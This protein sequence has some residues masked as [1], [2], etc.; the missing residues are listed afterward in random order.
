MACP[1]LFGELG[2]DKGGFLYGGGVRA[3]EDCSCELLCCHAPFC[4]YLD[5]VYS[6]LCKYCGGG[7][8]DWWQL[9]KLVWASCLYTCL[10]IYTGLDLTAGI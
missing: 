2:S 5:A 8:R 10:K 7:V 9:I 6:H 4:C 1:R 3:V